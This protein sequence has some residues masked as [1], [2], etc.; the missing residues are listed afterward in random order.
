MPYARDTCNYA[1][2]EFGLPGTGRVTY[3]IEITVEPDV[4]S[5]R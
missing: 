1:L 5:L 3:T 2:V 4:A